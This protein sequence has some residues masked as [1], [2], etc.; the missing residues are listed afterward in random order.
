MTVKPGRVIDIEPFERLEGKVRALVAVVEQL[1]AEKAALVD[2]NTRLQVQVDAMQARLAEA[3]QQASAE[4]LA[5]RQ[6]R[7]QVRQRVAS[8]LEQIEALDL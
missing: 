6:E 1:R 4:L 5:L 8:L 3:E 7:D 2:E